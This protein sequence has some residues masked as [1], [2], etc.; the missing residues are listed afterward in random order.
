MPPQVSLNLQTFPVG[1]NLQKFLPV[2]EKSGCGG[3]RL[4][5]YPIGIWPMA[6]GPETNLIEA[7]T[8][9]LINLGFNLVHMQSNVEKLLGG[10]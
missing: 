5:S 1:V 10:L 6:R 4:A 8:V 3:H 7:I 2:H 9:S